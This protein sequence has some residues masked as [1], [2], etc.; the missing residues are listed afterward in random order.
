MADRRAL[1]VGINQFK[2]LPSANW[3]NGCVNDAQDMVG[4]LR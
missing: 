2:D 1:C 3:L 4:I